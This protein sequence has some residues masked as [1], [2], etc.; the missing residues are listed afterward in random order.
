MKKITE[1]SQGDDN[2]NLRKIL[3]QFATGV[4][5]VTTFGQDEK[6]CGITINSLTSVSLDPPL[7][8]FCLSKFS[9]TLN[10]FKANS[11]FAINILDGEQ[12]SISKDF[13]R[14]NFDKF[15]NVNWDISQHKCP[16]LYGNIATI[17][18]KKTNEFDGGDH[19]IILGEIIN[20]SGH[21]SHDPLIYHNGAYKKIHI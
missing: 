6:P 20:A 14:P 8:L 16:I 7:L 17:E 18:C 12:K 1:Y 3:G 13:A 15:S 11:Y 9:G 19:I 5:I 10:A 4:A 2:K 21:E